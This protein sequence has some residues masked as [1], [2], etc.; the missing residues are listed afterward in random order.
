VLACVVSWEPGKSAGPEPLRA[1]LWLTFE[2]GIKAWLDGKPIGESL[3]MQSAIEESL[4]LELALAP[5]LHELVVLLPDDRGAAAF[6]ARFSD[7]EGKPLPLGF[8]LA[9]EPPRSAKKR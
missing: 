6:A 2:D 7:A 9:A 3:R 8:T 4:S 1:L 5:G